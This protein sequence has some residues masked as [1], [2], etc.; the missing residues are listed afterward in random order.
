[1]ETTLNSHPTQLSTFAIR[2]TQRLTQNCKRAY[3][4]ASAFLPTLK[5]IF[6]ETLVLRLRENMSMNNLLTD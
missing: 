3:L 2:T 5:T 1:M 4:S 6:S